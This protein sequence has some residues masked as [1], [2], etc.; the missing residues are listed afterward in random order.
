[1]SYSYNNLINISYTKQEQILLKLIKQTWELLESKAKLGLDRCTIKLELDCVECLL[2]NN[3]EIFSLHY[4]HI[5]KQYMKYFSDRNFNVNNV[6]NR[7]IEGEFIK[8]HINGKVHYYCRIS[9]NRRCNCVYIE[10]DEEGIVIDRKYYDIDGI[11]RDYYC[12][13]T[14]SIH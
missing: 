13:T 5:Y 10:Y 4:K 3:N 12:V 7:M 11:E 2:F 1:M 9:N 6:D 14:H 8:Y